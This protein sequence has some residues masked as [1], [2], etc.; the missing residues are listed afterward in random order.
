[1][2]TEKWRLLW[3]VFGALIWALLTGYWWQSL[4]LFMGVYALWMLVQLT[5][6]EKWLSQGAMTHNMPR[7]SG[8]WDRVA[9]HTIRL[10]SKLKNSHKRYQ[11]LIIRFNEILHSFP[12]AT[13]V[14]NAN[15]EIQWVSKSAANILNLNRKKDNGIRIDNI[16]R[17]AHFQDLLSSSDA[18]E[19]QM[20]SPIQAQVILMVA[21]SRLNKDTRLLSIRDVSE[22]RHLEDLRTAF[23]AN[24]SH[25]LK[26][27][28]TLVSGYL[29]MLAADD[30]LPP[31]TQAMVANACQHSQR[32]N[33]LIADLL[34]LSNLENSA[35]YTHEIEVVLMS[36]IIDEACTHLKAS[37]DISQTLVV[38]VTQDLT[39]SGAYYQLYSLVLNLLENAIKY[40]EPTGKI[41]IGWQAQ[42][43]QAVLTV[44]NQGEGL[45]EPQLARLT[46]PFYRPHP[47]TQQSGTGLGLSIVAKIAKIHH[48][49]LT[50]NSKKGQ[51]LVAEVCFNLSSNRSRK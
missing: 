12:Y 47:P 2:G 37:L 45:S 33:Y 42:D 28:L 21:I 30:T 27:P 31:A 39:V 5:R 48:A 8:L 40:G 26:P 6:L 13:V 41:W 15:N 51:G 24:A 18:S 44:R 29:E 17:Q 4:L 35:K 22:R 43:G 7:S 19:F 25:E 14:I 3:V 50:L 20:Y 49:T 46:E 38:N 11:K 9:G 32:I 36:K 23:I 1:M 10:Q 34:L 16:I